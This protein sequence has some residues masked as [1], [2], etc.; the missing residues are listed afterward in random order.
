MNELVEILQYG[1]MQKAFITGIFISLCSSILGI[2]LVLRKQSL[3][4]DGLSHVSFAS[5][6]FSL[7]IGASPLLLSIP[8]VIFASFI[9]YKL[10]R[11][12]GLYSDASIG[13]VSATSVAIGVLII[14][15]SKGFNLDI[16]SY[17]F[18]SILALS[19]VEVVLSIIVSL[20]VIA[21]LFLFFQDLYLMTYD[22]EYA[23]ISGINVSLISLI[24]VILQS[25]TIVI[26][27]KMVGAMLISSLIIFPA[28]T[29]LQLA[30]NF[31]TMI[32]MSV[33]ISLFSVIC[34]IIVSF[35]GNFP[36]GATIVCINAILF[37][38]VFFITKILYGK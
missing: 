15:I 23:R 22:E 1:F 26:G 37:F 18:G 14:S 20:I 31:K 38:I 19:E 27:V 36:T 16:Y 28:I 9:I 6:A 11:D 34:G 21:V 4:S 35:F 29:S 24:F 7:L 30:R 2:F 12:A 8:V 5:V 32:L 33:I 3:I 13:L 25:V 10:T 17:L